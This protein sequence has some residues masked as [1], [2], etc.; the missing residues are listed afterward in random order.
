MRQF[1]PWLTGREPPPPARDE[2]EIDRAD[3]LTRREQDAAFCAA[4]ARA[5]RER[6]ESPPML[7]ID[8]RPGTRS[9]IVMAR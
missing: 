9:P 6:R 2:I 7:G 8:T 3:L 1:L 5:V 4:M